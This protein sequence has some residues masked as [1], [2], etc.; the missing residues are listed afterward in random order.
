MK[1]NDIVERLGD[2]T[3]G[4][5]ETVP[6]K[7]YLREVAHY[8]ATHSARE[9]IVSASEGALLAGVTLPEIVEELYK[10]KEIHPA[11]MD[12]RQKSSNISKIIID[13]SNLEH[14]G[15]SEAQGLYDLLVPMLAELQK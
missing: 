15:V 5:E 6:A 12:E 9:F 11:E 7:D 4:K 10:R 8:I 14:R 3:V 2:V 13:L 1:Y